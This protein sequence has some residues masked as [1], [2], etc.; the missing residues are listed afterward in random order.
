MPAVDVPDEQHERSLAAQ[1][2]DKSAD[3]LLPDT[4]YDTGTFVRSPGVRPTPVMT[5]QFS[6]TPTPQAIPRSTNPKDRI[7]ITKP[8]IHLVPPVAIIHE[9]MAMKDGAEKYGPYNWRGESVS[10]SVYIAACYRHLMAWFDREEHAQDSGVHHLG[11]ARACLAIILDA[12]S[13]GKLVDDRPSP[14][15]SGNLLPLLSTSKKERE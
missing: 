2:N 5:G 8:P 11:H 14:G 6:V 7:G 4:R 1:E 12:M 15:F 10:A 13:V 3:S 9:S